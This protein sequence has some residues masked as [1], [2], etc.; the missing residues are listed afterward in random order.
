MPCGGPDHLDFS[1]DGTY[2]MIGCE[3][4]GSV[5]KVDVKKMTVVDTMNIAGLPVDVKLAPDGT[6][7]FV[8]NQGTGGVYVID[9]VRMEVLKFIRT[10][11]APMAWRSA[12]TPRGCICRTAWRE[13]SP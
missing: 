9:P 12:A 5:V 3:F 8:A 6:V 11:E 2:L 13:R 1:A 4:D 10:A 7:F